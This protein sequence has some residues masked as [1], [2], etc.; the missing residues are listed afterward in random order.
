M[1]FRFVALNSNSVLAL[2]SA[3][4]LTAC[5]GL[6]QGDLK[7]EVAS[8]HG[9]F[10]SGSEAAARGGVAGYVYRGTALAKV[11]KMDS[12]P[13][14]V[15]AVAKPDRLSLSKAAPTRVSLSTPRIYFR[16]GSAALSRKSKATLKKFANA[17]PQSV[18]RIQVV[19]FADATGSKALNEKLTQER[20]QNV[21]TYLKSQ[22]KFSTASLEV[23]A[24]GIDAHA[25]VGKNA[26][27]SRRVE[28]ETL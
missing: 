4:F 13:A 12:A 28:L 20:A 14:S 9:Y 25:P 16:R 22:A 18:A 7:P 1:N 3:V 10:V 26:P 17:V 11:A 21:A 2:G 24:S 6:P 5:A 23:T 8:A 19:G 15:R 27:L